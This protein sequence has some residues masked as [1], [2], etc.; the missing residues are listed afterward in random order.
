MWK[1]APMKVANGLVGGSG[2]NNRSRASK[3]ITVQLSTLRNHS[4]NSF[5]EDV[6]PLSEDRKA[7]NELMEDKRLVVE[8]FVLHCVLDMSQQMWAGDPCCLSQMNRRAH[9]GVRW[10]TGLNQSRVPSACRAKARAFAPTGSE[11]LLLPVS[12][13]AVAHS[14]MLARALAS[15]IA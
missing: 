5:S 1:P 10:G 3:R 15:I 13:S 8:F 14:F 4:K 11:L 7:Q 6:S 9:F 2:I 12:C